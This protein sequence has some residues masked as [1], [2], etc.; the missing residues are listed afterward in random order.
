MPYSD[1]DRQRAW[2]AARQRRKRAERRGAKVGRS[3]RPQALSIVVLDGPA[4]P[5]RLR[6]AAEIIGLL[7]DEVTL[8]RKNGE[9]MSPG[10]RLRTLG[11]AL[12]IAARLLEVGPLEE[13]LAALEEAIEQRRRTG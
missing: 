3:D 11:Y 2:D 6:S 9:R 5:V 1:P 8:F 13:R 10:D 12:G 7:E 4:G